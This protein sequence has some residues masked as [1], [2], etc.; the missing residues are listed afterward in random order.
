M[1]EQAESPSHVATE[2]IT[3][4]IVEQSSN[5]G[6]DPNHAQAIMLAENMGPGGSI[7]AAIDTR[8]V[9]PKGA[10]GIMQ[11]MPA[12]KNS[13][14][15]QG[16][17]SSE[18]TQSGNWKSSVNAGLAALKEIQGRRKTTDPRILAAE[19]NAGPK[20]GQMLLDGTP[21]KLPTETQDY[22]K[23]FSFAQ[24][25][26]QGMDKGTGVAR[27]TRTTQGFKATKD[28]VTEG[29]TVTSVQ[30]MEAIE[31][32]LR[33]NSVFVDQSVRTLTNSM[34]A[35]VGAHRV[36]AESASI[37]GQQAGLAKQLEGTI[38]AAGAQARARILNI[39]GL[40]TNK[41]DNIV[42]ARTAE[43]QEL[44][45]SRR[46]QAAVIDEKTSVGFFDNPL[47]Y[48]INATQ[49]PGMVDA[50]NATVRKQNDSLST[51]ETM[52]GIAEKQGR[53]D[54]AASADQLAAVGVA[55][56]NAIVAE[57][58]ARAAKLKADAASGTARFTTTIAGLHEK[59]LDNELR[60]AVLRKQVESYKEGDTK[61]GKEA[62]DEA[63]LDADLRRI[64][65]MVGAPNMSLSVLKRMSKKEQ[66][67]WLTRVS[68]NN[69]GNNLYEALTFLKPGN[70][71]NMTKSGS[72][73]LV[74]SVRDLQ[75]VA[76]QK[77]RMDAAKIRAEGGKVPSEQQLLEQV[78]RDLESEFFATSQDM[79]LASPY[80]PYKANHNVMATAWNG[81]PNNMLFK[82][83]RNG[84]IK[85]IKYTDQQLFST[86]SKLVF[87]GDMHPTA[88]AQQMS[89]YYGAAINRNNGAYSYELLGLP[90][91]T[92]YSVLPKEVKKSVDLTKPNEI[93]NVLT[94]IA[95]RGETEKHFREY[96]MIQDLTGAR[97]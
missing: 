50:H 65:N 68:T 32:L 47:Q 96:G 2:E 19:Y 87:D 33:D 5:Y 40:D 93:E 69:I 55:R 95:I 54:L 16:H 53:I 31:K 59:R 8:K 73:A 1:A 81:D 11:V 7:P 71:D 80:N 94:T 12:T 25:W 88:A 61:K 23:K 27:P 48:I 79:L 75:Q 46:R 20:G 66:D 56:G 77:A 51:L 45:A 83:V 84:V 6:V 72:A 60:V 4:Y 28:G 34:E 26:L 44:D 42:V 41:I 76:V 97:Q 82:I 35:E 3:R 13:L 17:L 43:F 38:D 57:G 18:H 85:K 30:N 24:G 29:M 15:E 14:V 70:L 62:E 22:L 90:K 52:Q 37:S 9:S 58:N 74:E 10:S 36:A 64:G 91:Q 89:D 67:E 86:I 49:L 78:G 39:L 21:E 92:D 63:K